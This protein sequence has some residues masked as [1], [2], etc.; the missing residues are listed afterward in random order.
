MVH[1]VCFVYISF[2]SPYTCSI[3]E[4][5]NTMGRYVDAVCLWNILEY[6]WMFDLVLRPDVMSYMPPEP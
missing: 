2:T 3:G 4:Q 1:G 6:F 5:I